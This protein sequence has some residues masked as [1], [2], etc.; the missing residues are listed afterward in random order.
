MR[1]SCTTCI[2]G[3]IAETLQPGVTV[4]ATLQDLGAR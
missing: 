1:A 4:A 3:A 2:L